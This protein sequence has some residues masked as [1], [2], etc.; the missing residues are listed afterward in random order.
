MWF[1]FSE[2]NF[3]HLGLQQSHFS[4]QTIHRTC[5][6]TNRERFKDTYYAFPATV[7]DIFLDIQNPDLGEKHIKKPKPSY[8]LLALRFL[9]KYPTKYNLAAVSGATEKTALLRVWKYVDAI[10]ALKQEKVREVLPS[11][12]VNYWLVTFV[13]TLT[14]FNYILL[15]IQWIFDNDNDFDNHDVVS[16]DGVHFWI[17]EPSKFLSTTWYSP[18]Y[19]K[20]ALTYEIALSLYHDKIVWVNGPFPAGEN[21]K[22]VFNKPDGLASKLKPGQVAIGDEGYV[23]QKDKV[24]ARNSLNDAT[25]KEIKKRSKAWQETINS[26][27]KAFGILNQPFRCTGAHRLPRHKAALEACLVI[28]Q[29]ELENGSKLL[30]I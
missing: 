16:V 13:V 23:G 18:K 12:S 9:K 5:D 28:I 29:Y 15:Q 4:V 25:T 30:R 24:V 2:N 17:W 27:L 6:K 26:R 1:E 20:A 7:H 3:F 10:Q 22:K 8:L 19:K 14:L 11:L 21:D